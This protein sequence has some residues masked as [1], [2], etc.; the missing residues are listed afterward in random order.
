MTYENLKEGERL[1]RLIKEYEQI[2]DYFERTTDKD[3]KERIAEYFTGARNVPGKEQMSQVAINA[4][5]DSCE[6]CIKSA[7]ALFEK[8]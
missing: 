6:A 8:L 5:V 1:Q 3:R 2:L 7:Q 4:I